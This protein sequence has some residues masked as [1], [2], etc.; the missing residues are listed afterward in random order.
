MTV[1]ALGLTYKD[2]IDAAAVETLNTEVKAMLESKH[3]Q[4]S[5][6]DAIEAVG[7]SWGFVL[8]E[9]DN[10]AALI[11]NADGQYATVWYESAY[12]QAMSVYTTQQYDADAVGFD[13]QTL[14]WGETE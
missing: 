8:I 7:D 1:Q 2:M 9:R 12:G 4:M 13:N 6:E 5:A 3:G 10:E 14:G 11:R